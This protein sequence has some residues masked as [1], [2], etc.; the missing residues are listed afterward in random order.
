MGHFKKH[1]MIIILPLFIL[2]LIGCNNKSLEPLTKSSYLLNTVVTITIYDKT[3]E[4]ILNDSLALIKDYEKIFSRTDK[5]SELYKLNNRLI[6]KT[7]NN[8]YIISD[9]LAYIINKSLE[10]S[11]LSDGAFDPTIAP[12]SDLW[13][14]SNLN[15]VPK[16]EDIEK[17]L[18]LIDYNKINLINNE[19]YFEN[20]YIQIDLGAIA[21]GYIADKTKEFLLKEGINSAIINLGGNVLTIG[22]KP[23]G[24][25][26]KI[27]LQKPFA[28][29]NETIATMNINDLTVVSSGIYE[30]YFTENDILYHHILNPK[31]GFPFD[32]DLL[33]V[34]IITS[35][36]TD[37]DALSTICLSL[38]L[39]EA[40]ELINTLPN[41][42]AAFITKDYNIYYSK[43]FQD[44]IILT[45]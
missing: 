7:K 23:N 39:N 29:R 36:S 10:Y 19:I 27:G 42:Y 12:L 24:E 8:G 3:N 5:D 34:T 2:T 35:S 44:N 31:T 43:D 22:N 28:N 26:F 11:S 38:G 41:T 13:D 15:N 20:A 1:I 14:F 6:E 33:S 37:A 9:E 32:N 25:D 18:P 30:R 40:L 16:I 21:K 45:N 17:L 4:S